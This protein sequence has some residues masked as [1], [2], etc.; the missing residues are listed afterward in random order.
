ML[1]KNNIELIKEFVDLDSAHRVWCLSEK[2]FLLT[3]QKNQFG[4]ITVID[5]FNGNEPFLLDADFFKYERVPIIFRPVLLLDSNIV[6]QLHHVFKS[7][8]I[9]EEYKD[10]IYALIES[11]ILD[12]TV[13]IYDINPIFYILE[14]LLKSLPEKNILENLE[15]ILL[16]QSLDYKEFLHNRKIQKDQI[17][18][19]IYNDVY[20]TCD[21]AEI[22]KIKLAEIKND[23]Q[24][25]HQYRKMVNITHLLLLK[26]AQINIY[27]KNK[28]AHYR[29]NS[30]KSF[31]V[32]ILGIFSAREISIAT[33]Y[34]NNNIAGFIPTEKK[35]SDEILQ[36]I[37]NSALDISLLRW[38]EI[39]LSKSCR[40]SVQVVYAVTR[41]KHLISLGEQMTLS[42]MLVLENE[43]YTFFENDISMIA[44]VK[45]LEKSLDNVRFFEEEVFLSRF[46]NRKYLLPEKIESM[47]RDIELSIRQMK[48]AHSN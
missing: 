35:N 42:M 6:G 10:E 30:V 14:S 23:M 18:D 2:P 8:K 33:Y 27:E 3:L 17:F 32:D 12:E 25:I 31:C 38:S 39:M 15:S 22:A 26:I 1:C 21:L 34:M 19:E 5:I 36:I 47:I 28:P 4:K 44:E 46:E 11:I 45:D 13:K 43:F 24:K 29:I 16:L 37:F 20:K 41:E 48:E 40:E 7:N 9:N